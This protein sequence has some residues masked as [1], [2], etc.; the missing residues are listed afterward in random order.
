MVTEVSTGAR[1]PA[2]F[3]G[4]ARKMRRK[5]EEMH[6][7]RNK[8]GRMGRAAFSLAFQAWLETAL[9]DNRTR[10]GNPVPQGCSPAPLDCMTEVAGWRL[11]GL[12]SGATKKENGQGREER[13]RV[14]DTGIKKAQ[15]AKKQGNVHRQRI[16]WGADARS[17]LFR[18]LSHSFT[19]IPA[20]LSS[21]FLFPDRET[22][23]DWLG[24]RRFSLS[25]S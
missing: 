12:R 20:L 23:L 14:V 24:R 17:S 18:F 8:G 2:D 16:D 7:H 13:P 25:L 11:L 5:V 4:L 1:L 21:F 22:F 19:F 9:V 6:K 3:Q 10:S 15:T